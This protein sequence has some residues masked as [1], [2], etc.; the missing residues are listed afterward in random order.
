MTAKMLYC[1]RCGAANSSQDVTCFACQNQ[2]GLPGDDDDTA[3]ELIG[4]RYRVLAQVGVGGFATV[5][6][7][8]DTQEKNAIRALKQINLSKLTAQQAIEATDAFN[9]EV[10]LLSQLAHINLPHVYHHFTDP[11]HW[12]LVMDFIEGETLE[13]YL[14]LQVSSTPAVAQ[15]APLLPFDEIFSIALQL[16]EVLSYLHG[17]QP[18][19]IF[20]DLKPSNIMRSRTGQL[21]LIDFGI[22]RRF[23][24][25]QARDTIPFG[26]PG[27]AAPEQYGKAQT[28]PASDIFSLGALLHYLLSGEDPV[29]NPFKFSPISAYGQSGVSELAT[30]VERMVRFNSAERPSSIAEIYRE[31]LLIKR[32]GSNPRSGTPAPMRVGGASTAGQVQ[33]QTSW[34]VLTRRRIRRRAILVGCTVLG[35]AVAF[36]GVQGFNAYRQAKALRLQENIL[37]DNQ[38]MYTSVLAPDG[39]TCVSIDTDIF[40]VWD[41]RQNRPIW[42]GEEDVNPR[43]EPTWSPDSRHFATVAGDGSVTVWDW[44]QQQ[45][46]HVVAAYP[47]G[48]NLNAN[49]CLAWSPD[50]RYIAVAQSDAESGKVDLQIL[51]PTSG[52]VIASDSSLFSPILALDWSP[53]SKML[54]T[55]NAQDV[56]NVYEVSPLFKWRHTYALP[57]AQLFPHEHIDAVVRWSP[58]GNW[59]AAAPYQGPL[60]IWSPITIQGITFADPASHRNLI[61]SGLKWSP[62]GKH[63]AA[64][65]SENNMSFWNVSTK[66]VLDTSSVF[67]VGDDSSRAT[68]YWRSDSQSVDIIDVH[69]RIINIPIPAR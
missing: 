47:F 64:F 45:T 67:S 1:A 35:V 59:I 60:S 19:V 52:D 16:C 44:R 4:G 28:T 32:A 7:V 63:L 15:P 49:T 37:N 17:R 50:G 13:R 54:V 14:E 66:Q 56:L 34:P 6:Q 18:P 29:E 5:Y 33:I 36:G 65:N 8:Q 39:H 46:T 12:Y 53:D 23:K 27:Y 58:D 55:N 68:L 41:I 21:Y 57:R 51:N 69:R 61:Y 11:E 48:R 3:S 2:L 25:G 22:A 10:R 43:P 38:F 42:D 31:I 24:P 20:R 26:S 9:R 62:N 40:L 30:L